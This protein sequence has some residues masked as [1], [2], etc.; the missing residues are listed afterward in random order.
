MGP[1]FSRYNHIFRSPMKIF[2]EPNEIFV[3]RAR[4]FVSSAR[5]PE[6]GEIFGHILPESEN[7]WLIPIVF[8]VSS[9]YMAEHMAE[10]I[11][12]Q[13]RIIRNLVRF[14]GLAPDFSRSSPS[15]RSPARIFSGPTDRT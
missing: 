3:D 6:A 10:N 2:P 5:F 1:E 11:A 7:I 12:R 4:V 8:T 9:K 15:F 14:L 13:V